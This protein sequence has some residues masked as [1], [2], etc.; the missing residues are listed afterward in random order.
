MPAKYF[1]TPSSVTRRTSWSGLKNL[2][3]MPFEFFD[4]AALRLAKLDTHFHRES[5]KM[6]QPNPAPVS[7]KS[8]YFT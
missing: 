6:F 2:K 1:L 4:H 5:D 7:C 3:S 8:S